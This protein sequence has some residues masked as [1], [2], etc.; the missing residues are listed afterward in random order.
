[1]TAN[2]ILAGAALASGVAVAATQLARASAAVTELVGTVRQLV[3]KVTD[4]EARITSL[5]QHKAPGSS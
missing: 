2:W 1:M 4:H 5:E 3:D